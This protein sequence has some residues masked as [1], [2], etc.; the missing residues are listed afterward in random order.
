MVDKIY[1]LI[2]LGEIAEGYDVE[3]IQEKWAIIFDIDLKK[4]PKLLKKLTIIRKNL[5]YDVALEYKNGHEQI[6]VLCKI[7]I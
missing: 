4:I 2:I 5:S 1:K 6:G 3:I 7:S